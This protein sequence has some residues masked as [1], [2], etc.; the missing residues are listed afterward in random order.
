MIVLLG[1]F[2][3]SVSLAQQADN[4]L[5]D[6]EPSGDFQLVVDGQVA[7]DAKI[8]QSQRAAAFLIRAPQLP[9][10]VLL[11]PRTGS[12]ETVS[13]MSLALRSNGVVDILADAQSTPQGA[14]RLDGEEVIFSVAGK[15]LKLVPRPD[16]TGFHGREE[17]I[18]HNPAY[19]YKAQGYTPDATDLAQLKGAG[20][21]VQVRVF[22][23]SWCPTCSRYVPLVMKVDEEL[24][25]TVDFRYYGLPKQNFRNDPE[26]KRANITGVPTIVVYRGGKEVGRLQSTQWPKPEAGITALLNQG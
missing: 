16:L 9:E 19:G 1:I 22:F 23:G 20:A 13:L 4:V 24:G 11:S 5:R 8:N 2:W 18:D 26:A 3:I 25:G 6:F 17:M 21:D 15:Q 12:V 14:F 7:K 10:P